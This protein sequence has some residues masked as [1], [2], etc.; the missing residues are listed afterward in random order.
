TTDV[1]FTAGAEVTADIFSEITVGQTA[2]TSTTN[3]V[4]DPSAKTATVTR[5]LTATRGQDQLTIQASGSAALDDSGALLTLTL[6]LDR[7]AT[8]NG[9]TRQQTI[10]GLSLEEGK[11][12]PTSGA[13]HL[14][15]IRGKTLDAVFSNDG[16]GTV[17]IEVTLT[18]RRGSASFTFTV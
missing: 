8:L 7:T 1:T 9:D 12:L 15:G 14:S 3:L 11:R 18:G 13:I 10:D 6:N 4:I 5:S 2:M 17:S 16:A